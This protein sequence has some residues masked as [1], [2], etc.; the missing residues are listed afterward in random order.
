MNSLCNTVPGFA[1]RVFLLIE[2]RL[3]R[4][5]L[6]RLF[7]KRPDLVVVGE[8]EHGQ[9]M[10]RP[11]LDS[12][13]DVLVA[14]SFQTSWL[15]ENI[16]P[17]RGEQ[18]TFRAVVIGMESDEEQ[19]MAAVR[20]GITGYL[21]KE[22]S[23]SDVVAA[24]RAV[25]RGEAVCP[26]QLC[27]TLF[28]FV[29][30]MAKEMPVQRASSKPDLTL[31][32]QQLVSLVAKGLTNKEIASHLNLSEFTVRNHI[33]RILK[34]VDAGSRSEAVETIRAYGYQISP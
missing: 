29:A 27:S 20:S 16:A 10:G 8:G 34:Q 31:R 33:H 11:V 12:S 9:A 30:Q 23:A 15:R 26:P 24:V 32:Q 21:L 3:L 25:F 2:N 5:A 4:E 28:R 6:V 1:I 7:R 22:A 14:D 19:F 13:C 17:E 18:A